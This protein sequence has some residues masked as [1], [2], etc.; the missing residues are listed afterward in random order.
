[1][2]GRWSST[3]K[4]PDKLEFESKTFKIKFTSYR[5]LEG[6]AVQRFPE[7]KCEKKQLAFFS[8]KTQTLYELQF[9]TVDTSIV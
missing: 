8:G 1:M 4:K 9:I 3:K 7:K 6:V 2:W 5:V